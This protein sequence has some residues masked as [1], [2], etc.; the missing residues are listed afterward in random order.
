MTLV[1]TGLVRT[2]KQL[3]KLQHSYVEIDQVDEELILKQIQDPRLTNKSLDMQIELMF[4]YLVSQ[5]LC[6][7]QL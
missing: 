4:D 7:V 3:F 2:F 1:Q 5:G 6:D